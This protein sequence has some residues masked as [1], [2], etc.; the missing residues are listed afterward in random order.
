M[1]GVLAR[2]KGA[3]EACTRREEKSRSGRESG[4][5]RGHTKS[6]D[7]TRPHA[8]G[9]ELVPVSTCLAMSAPIVGIRREGKSRWERRSPLAPQHVKLLVEK[10][11][12][13]IVQPSTIRV[14]HD[15]KYQEVRLPVA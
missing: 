10:G 13:V 6:G 11:I 7:G 14:Y 9:T 12:K 2:D 4:E 1:I 15:S 3:N 8:R 5:K